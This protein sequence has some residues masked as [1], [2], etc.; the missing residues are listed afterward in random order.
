M[1]V[2]CFIIGISG[3]IV[4]AFLA[5]KNRKPWARSGNSRWSDDANKVELYVQTKVAQ[6][7]IR[8]RGRCLDVVKAGH[9]CCPC[10]KQ[11]AYNI[12]NPEDA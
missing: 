3:W 7:V 10:Y 4:A 11:L 12:A 6:G 9:G 8:E 2:A 1:I 5:A